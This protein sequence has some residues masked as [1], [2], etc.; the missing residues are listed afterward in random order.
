[1][2][3]LARIHSQ[4]FV[5]A[6]LGLSTSAFAAEGLLTPQ[7]AL[8]LAQEKNP[9]I[10]AAHARAEAE[11]AMV[12]SSSW[13]DSPRIGFMREQNLNNMQLEMGPM[14]F[15]SV[16][17]EVKFPLKYF[18]SGS[19]QKSRADASK[20][21]ADDKSLEI[22][23]RVLTAYYNVY[24]ARR[25]E[26]LLQAQRE[27]LREIARAAEAR[28]ATGAVPQQD[29]MKAHVEQTRIENEI[30]LQGQETSEMEAML[31]S[32]LNVDPNDEIRIIEKDLPS[33]K[34]S[35]SS[36]KEAKA[37]VPHGASRL[38]LA[39]ESMLSQARSESA[40]AW[41][42]FAPDFM[43]SY[44]QAFVN[45]P[46]NAYAFSIEATIPLWFFA[47]EIPEVRAA[48]ARAAEA[49]ANLTRMKRETEAETRSLSTRVE[50]YSK[51]IQI[52]ETSLIPQSISML[53]SSRAAYS[54]GRT[55][56]VELL[57]SE[58]SLYANRIAYFQTLTKYVESLTRLE[59]VLGTSI[60]D[61]PFLAGDQE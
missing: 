22:R 55:T 54:A 28:R 61:L 8:Q 34:L 50:S 31:R 60:S 25:I 40:L 44:R 29:E 3:S 45:A 26:A 32:L 14:A 5:T 56:F 27:T 10:S 21:E 53:N 37:Q 16:S 15:W 30:L 24:S 11:S 51:L 57:D 52:Y 41:L 4:V 46:P 12:W 18:V 2:K 43:L 39:G 47:K 36:V 7:A 13:L 23:Q 17:Q 9:E 35:L 48:R 1:L 49:E 58:R 33:P 38:V 6:F 42:G 20:H 59:R 19:A